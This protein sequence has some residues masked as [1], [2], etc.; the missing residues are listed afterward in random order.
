MPDEQTPALL[1]ALDDALMRD[2]RRLKQWSLPAKDES[3]R[4][5]TLPY[6]WHQAVHPV[7]FEHTLELDESLRGR[8][9]LLRLDVAEGLLLVD[10]EPFHGLDRNHRDVVLPA[11]RTRGDV[12]ALAIEASRAAPFGGA[13]FRDA[14][15]VPFRESVARLSHYIAALD[16]QRESL[17]P[18]RDRREVEQWLD[19]LA[20]LAAPGAATTSVEPSFLDRDEAGITPA[21]TV[22]SEQDVAQALAAVERFVRHGRRSHGRRAGLVH[23]VGHSH[24]DVVWLWTL[25]ETRR[26]CAR[27][28]STALRLMER[29]PEFQFAESQALLYAFVRQSYPSIYGQVRQRVREGRWHPVGSTWVEPDC[30]IPSGESLIRQIQHGRRFFDREFG[31]RDEVLWLPDTFGYAWSLPQILRLSGIRAFFTTKL[32]WNDTNRF[33]HHSFWWEGLDGSRVLAHNPPVG[34]EGLPSAQH[35]R[36]AWNSYRE[37]RLAPH[38]LQTFGFGDGGGGVTAEQLDAVAVLGAAPGVPAARRSTVSRFFEALRRNGRRLP[39][40]R[41][42]LYLELHRGTYTTHAWLKRAN[43][44]AESSLYVTESLCALASGTYDDEAWHTVTETLDG[45]WKRLLTNQFHDI[46]PGTAIEAAYEDTRRDFSDLERGCETLQQAA[47]DRAAPVVAPATSDAFTVFNPLAWDRLSHVV[48]PPGTRLAAV[49][50]H[51]GQDVPSQVVSEHGRRRVIC[52]VRV[53]ALGCAR[54]KLSDATVPMLTLTPAV[55]AEPAVLDA[56]FVRVA[57]D[58][59]GAITSLLDK[60]SGRDVVLGGARLNEFLT[61]R[62]EPKH[63][64]AWDIDPDYENK[65]VEVFRE[66]SVEVLERGPLRWRARI[67]R[68]SAGRTRLEQDVIAWHDAAGV[69]FVTRVHWHEQRTLLKVAFPLAVRAGR[70]TY[71]IPFGAIDRPTVPRSRRDRARWEVAGQQWADLSERRF[72]VSLLNDSKYGYDCRAQVLRLT[73][74]RSP[75]YPDHA[76]PMTK[77][78]GR[79][80]DQG[81]HR[82]TYM[83]LPHAGTWREART[84]RHA[85]ELNVP[86]LVFDGWREPRVLPPLTLGNASNVQVS[87]IAPGDEPGDVLVRLYECH[88]TGGPVAIGIGWPCEAVWEVDLEGR[89]VRQVPVHD[90]RLALRFRPFEIKTLHVGPARAPAPRIGDGPRFPARGNRGRASISSPRKTRGPGDTVWPVESLAQRDA[91]W[92]PRASWTACTVDACWPQAE[93]RR[94]ETG[95]HVESR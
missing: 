78:S 26:K 6:H 42:E 61:F 17:R 82:F 41:D 51:S 5:V 20:R 48:L 70:A 44:R 87:A 46:V 24:I 10:G 21:P 12:I 74:I 60:A 73:L 65:P 76:E 3:A 62:D 54:L 28:F 14:R 7:R 23:L 31:V 39:V 16:G 33:P 32:L 53:P 8:T 40:W 66:A 4:A 9:L 18:G 19:E 69:E 29:Y 57:F 64:E 15:V 27:T 47:M 90:G 37:R 34:L 52:S 30:N 77:T 49:Q 55:P 80:T 86:G 92:T 63:W 35:L 43:R 2:A 85:R 36:K 67:T 13:W 81:E 71:E 59:R 50:D 11:D 83:L 75:R 93:D 91:R 72:G 58:E 79:C 89:R 95:G 88:G 94:R 1:R 25:A 38:V 84:V 56:P 45:L 68:R 22:L